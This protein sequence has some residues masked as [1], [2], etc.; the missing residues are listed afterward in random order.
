MA[1]AASPTNRSV[2]PT[3]EWTELEGM[4]FTLTRYVWV[5]IP[6]VGLPGNF[7]SILV[8]LQKDNRK[9]STCVYMVALACA[10]S[11][12]IGEN[13]GGTFVIFFTKAEELQMQILYYL[14][15]TGAILSGLVLMEMSVDRLIAVRYPMEART[16][17]TVSR[18]LKVITVSAIFVSGANLHIFFIFHKADLGGYGLVVS[19]PGHEEY[20]LLVLAYHLGV[21]SVI[22]FI[23]IVIC[24]V[25]IIATIRA[26]ANKREAM[27]QDEKGKKSSEKETR[28]LTRMLVIVCAAYVGLSLPYRLY[29]LI[30]KI[31]AIAQQ[32]QE[33]TNYW[34]WRRLLEVWTLSHIWDWNYA[35]NFYLY[36]IGGGKRYRSEVARLLG[37]NKKNP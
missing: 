9:V 36:C 13:I 6:G 2:L 26:A 25:F 27:G 5:I 33:K 22:P 29:D 34:R 18:A 23:I 11:L 7:L 20:E 14:S 12:S 24:N 19:S 30:L 1:M 21:G 3:T 28:Y 35:V 4:F 15:H 31:P 17:C 8:A 10:D 16:R 37:C 32:Y